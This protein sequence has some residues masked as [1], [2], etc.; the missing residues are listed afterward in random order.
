MFRLEI[1]STLHIKTLFAHLIL[2][3]LVILII[4]VFRKFMALI[5][6]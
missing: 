4:Q 2:L 3:T 6:E 1:P 5:K